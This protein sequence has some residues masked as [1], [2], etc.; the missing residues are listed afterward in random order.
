MSLY[1]NRYNKYCEIYNEL[2]GKLGTGYAG[3][4]SL[5]AN[6]SIIQCELPKFIPEMNGGSDAVSMGGLYDLYNDKYGIVENQLS[7]ITKTIT[8]AIALIEVRKTFAANMRDYYYNLYKQEKAA[9]EAALKNKG[10]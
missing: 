2:T 3:S 4:S 1:Y 6:S 7:R 5:Y 9:E 8:A 10:Y